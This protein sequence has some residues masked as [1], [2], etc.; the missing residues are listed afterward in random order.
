MSV[1]RQSTRGRRQTPQ[2][3]QNYES[4][5][6]PGAH[7]SK[8]GPKKTVPEKPLEEED[9][10]MCD[11]LGINHSCVKNDMIYLE[12]LNEFA[13]LQELTNK[14]ENSTEIPRTDQIK[15]VGLCAVLPFANLVSPG[16]SNHYS[17]QYEA[18]P[19]AS[20]CSNVACGT[21]YREVPA[22]S[23]AEL[24]Y[25]TPRQMY[26][27]I[28]TILGQLLHNDDEI[29][30]DIDWKAV[31]IE[32]HLPVSICKEF[33]WGFDITHIKDGYNGCFV[34]ADKRHNF[35]AGGN[36]YSDLEVKA[37]HRANT[38]TQKRVRVLS[39]MN[40]RMKANTQSSDINADPRKRPETPKRR[41]CFG[42]P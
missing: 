36:Y 7:T 32:S 17:T 16:F 23:R 10:Y 2:S 38:V 15:D 27:I 26:A 42:R 1:T 8:D 40:A 25:V 28:T 41:N 5:R 30:G 12:H 31:S 35:E 34:R 24:I 18:K 29:F 33:W 14:L 21:N 13:T 9:A 37:A 19:L 22:H 3:A 39:V 4:S 20:K 6:R 11:K